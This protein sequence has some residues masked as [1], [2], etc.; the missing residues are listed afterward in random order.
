M[1]M[2]TLQWGIRRRI[3]RFMW[4]LREVSRC[5]RYRK[6]CRSE[7]TRTWLRTTLPLCSLIL[8][9]DDCS[10][11]PLREMSLL[12][13]CSLVWLSPVT[14]HT[15]NKSPCSC[16][17]SRTNCWS[18]VGGRDG[19]RSTMTRSNPNR[20]RRGKMCW[21]TSVMSVRRIWQEGLFHSLNFC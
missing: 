1:T 16:T 19:L 3:C 6:E 17:M 20:W 12:S 8:G 21:G 7:C 9:R 18:L 4:D 11:A 14:P 2:T 5:G 13:M 15:S 10:L